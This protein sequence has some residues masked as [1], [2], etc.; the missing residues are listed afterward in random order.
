[1]IQEFIILWV[2]GLWAPTLGFQ[3]PCFLSLSKVLLVSEIYTWQ[4]AHKGVCACEKQGKRENYRKRGVKGKAVVQI[5][6][7][8]VIQYI[9]MY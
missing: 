5:A 9:N 2:P 4:W 1:M 3:P 7:I 6:L 8:Y